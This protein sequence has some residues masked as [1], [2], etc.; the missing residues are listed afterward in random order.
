MNKQE[1]QWSSH[2]KKQEA[3]GLN[4]KIYCD[5]ASLNYDQFRYWR[6]KYETKDR[7]AV[8]KCIPVRIQSAVEKSEVICSLVLRDGRR[9][10]F[11]D[12]MLVRDFLQGCL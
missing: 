10:E 9:L 2:V 12:P 3:S 7:S 5:Q 1:M 11:H 6:K 4:I 8:S